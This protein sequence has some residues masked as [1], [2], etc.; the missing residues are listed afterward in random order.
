MKIIHC[1]DLHLDSKLQTHLDSARAKERKGELLNTFERMVD[2]AHR[3]GVRAIL[4][5]GDLFDTGR[6]S[7][8]ARNL[9]RSVIRNHREID[10]YYLRGNH[11]GSGFL[12]DWTDQ[13]ENLKLFSEEWTAYALDEAGQVVL[14]GLELDES[15]QGNFT[16]TLILDADRFNLVML[17]GQESESVAGDKTEIIPL[18]ELRGKGIDYLALGHI[19]SYREKELDGRGVYCYPGCL[20]GRGFDET[21]DHGFVLLDIDEE[22][23]TC[24]R[25]FVPFARRKLYEIPVDITGCYTAPEM[26][27]RMEEALAEVHPEESSLVKTVLVGGMDVETEKDTEYLRARFSPDYYYFKVQDKTV[28]TLDPARYAKDISLKGEFVRLVL[29]REDLDEEK[30][31]AVIRYGLQAL[32]GEELQG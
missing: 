11:D 28:L 16:S 6:I 31:N 3:E 9:V 32:A 18:R 1:A 22:N 23:R 14:T 26:G 8:T 10:F 7:A 21:G 15:N 25:Q 2:Y 12:E 27:R 30:K 4:I 13:P 17:H 5:A 19:H 24:T 29:G 20:E